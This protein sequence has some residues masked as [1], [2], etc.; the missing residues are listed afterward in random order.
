MLLKLECWKSPSSKKRF[1]SDVV[2]PL[3][4]RQRPAGLS[5]Y[6]ESGRHED[7][8]E[9]ILG[10]GGQGGCVQ[11]SYLSLSSYTL[12][13]A[14]QGLPGNKGERGEKVGYGSYSNTDTVISK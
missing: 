10:G 2:L 13:F 14:L 9:L 1:V 11:R 5:V 4:T 8:G 12:W 7:V 6:K 3:L